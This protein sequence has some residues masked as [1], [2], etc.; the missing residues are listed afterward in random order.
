[1]Q[2]PLVGQIWGSEMANGRF[3]HAKVESTL[4]NSQHIRLRFLDDGDTAT[5]Q[6]AALTFM[7]GSN[8]RLIKDV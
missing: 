2:I 1:M 7:P 4:E 6:A 5:V 3:R 8:W